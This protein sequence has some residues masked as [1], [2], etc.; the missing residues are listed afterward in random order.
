MH[1]LCKNSGGR[2]PPTLHLYTVSTVLSPDFKTISRQ[3]SI[4]YFKSSMFIIPLLKYIML[5]DVFK[6]KENR[7]GFL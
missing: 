4:C 1:P 5:E 2:N 6:V 3:T 7:I